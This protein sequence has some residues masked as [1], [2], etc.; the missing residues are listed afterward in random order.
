MLYDNAQLA[1]VYLHTWQ[2]TGN[3]F[4]GTIKEEIL[5]YVMREVTD[6]AGEFY[7]TQDADSEGKEG[8][9]FVWTPDEIR[10]IVGGE[11]DAVMAAYGVTHHGN[12]EGKNIL[13][14]VGDL[15]EIAIVGDP[16]STDTQ[17]LLSV[18]RNGY[19]PFQAVALGAPYRLQ[20]VRRRQ[21]PNNTADGIGSIAAVPLLQDRG[22][23][24][25]AGEH[26]RPAAYV[27]RGFVCQKPVTEP[28]GLGALLDR[29]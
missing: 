9:L 20:L 10:E 19:R 21:L 2:V 26:A 6:P 11:E 4:Y 14:F 3:E 18:I 27:C 15:R 24:K 17:A 25:G 13:E 22:L 8:K 7:S 12:F 23:E 5:D 1:R 16:E 29:S 28:E